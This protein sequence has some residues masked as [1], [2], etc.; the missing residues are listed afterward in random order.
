MELG[1][2]AST[3]G[4]AARVSPRQEGWLV[5]RADISSEAG[6]DTEARSPTRR[7]LQRSSLYRERYRTPPTK[8]LEAQ[9]PNNC[10][11]INEHQENR[12]HV[13]P[14]ARDQHCFDFVKVGALLGC[15]SGARRPSEAANL[16]RGPYLQMDATSVVV[17]W[18]TDVAEIAACAMVS[19]RLR[20]RSR[21][22]PPPLRIIS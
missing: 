6:R 19:P 13:E 14:T 1:R 18:R 22:M 3:R 12:E 16:M 15:P 7:R 20:H 21:T 17:R 10:S 2:R 11:S 4:A 9:V 5:R 8:Q